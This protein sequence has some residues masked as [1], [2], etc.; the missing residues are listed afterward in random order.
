MT[1]TMRRPFVNMMGADP[2]NDN[3]HAFETSWLLLPFALF[4]VRALISLFVFTS[5]FTILGWNDTH[6]AEADNRLHFSFF[7][8]LTFWG[9]GFYFLFAAL[10][11]FLYQKTGRSVL[12]DKWP[13]ALRVLH[14][15]YYSTIITY[16][17][18]VTIIYWAILY[19][20]TWFPFVIDAWKNV[21][22]SLSFPWFDLLYSAFRN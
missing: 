9:V 6:G 8:N 17:F 5:I 15:L 14:S 22:R 11:T 13:R 16:P 12:L 10:H 7:T 19:N 20:G 18:I 2:S 3:I 1:I 4:C 21:R